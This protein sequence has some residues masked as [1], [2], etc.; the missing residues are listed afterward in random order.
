MDGWEAEVSKGYNEDME[1]LHC[2]LDKKKA[3]RWKAFG[4]RTQYSMSALMRVA[5]DRYI[6]WFDGLVAE[7]G[8][9]PSDG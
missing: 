7:D 5:V 6:E 3:Q 9:E 2:Y 1:I 8:K 4:D